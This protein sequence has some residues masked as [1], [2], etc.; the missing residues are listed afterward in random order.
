MDDRLPAPVRDRDRYSAI[1]VHQLRAGHWSGSQQYLHRIGRAPARRCPGCADVNCTGALCPTC[2]EA[3]DTPQH[4]L[5]DC[6][7]LLGPRLRTT[8]TIRPTMEEVRSSGVV[9]ALA[10]AARFL[11]G[12]QATTGP[13]RSGGT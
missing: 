7:A 11:Q 8:G 5:V 12:Q 3:A 13:A 2:R 9:A 10:A 1:D 4:V 6:P